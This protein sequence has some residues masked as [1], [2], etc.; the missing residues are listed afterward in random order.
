M[1]TQAENYEEEATKNI[2]EDDV[3]Q[4]LFVDKGKP[5]PN[6]RYA[7][8]NCD[9]KAINK[10]HIVEHQKR[11]HIGEN[12]RP[13]KIG[14]KLCTNN[15]NHVLHQN[16]TRIK[17]IKTVAGE[18]MCQENSC[19]FSTNQRD[20]LRYHYQNIHEGIK[21]Y[22]CSHCHY[23]NFD[24]ANVSRHQLQRHITENCRQLKIGC[25]LCT[26]NI[27]H[28]VHGTEIKP[29]R[30]SCQENS[31]S[32]KTNR[33]DS[34]T[35]HQKKI[36]DGI[37]RYLCSN[38]DYKAF[39]KSLLLRH[40][41]SRHIGENCRQLRIGC[42]PCTSNIEH[43]VHESET[44]SKILPD[45]SKTREYMCEEKLCNYITNNRSSLQDH[46]KNVHDK[47]KRYSCSNCNYKTFKRSLLLRHQSSRHFGEN[48][49]QL[50]IGC[51]PCASNIEHTV[52]ESERK[53]KTLA[54]KSK[55][56]EYV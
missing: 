18:F 3:I 21:R 26:S 44:K 35:T 6:R 7:C 34:L 41:S 19:N 32:Y 11:K 24:K 31:C 14:C 40:Q 4:S 33:R 48:C 45:K 20:K 43:N 54:V 16:K 17:S 29:N 36:H 55:T 22:S 42:G 51:G 52:H 2:I 27:E 13:L 37:S 12:C 50:R 49:R 47:I 10:S 46:Q 53:T 15:I 38:C 9:Y 5:P 25:G 56:R 8:S 1:A 28:T 30:Y 39:D 23:Q